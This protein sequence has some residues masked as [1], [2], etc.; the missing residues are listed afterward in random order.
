M[1]RYP[2]I[3][4]LMIV[5]TMSMAQSVDFDVC[6]ARGLQGL[7][8]QSS[9]LIGYIGRNVSVRTVGVGGPLRLEPVLIPRRITFEIDEDSLI[10]RI[11]C[12]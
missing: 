9:D 2:L 1:T 12:G 11:Y 3:V 7:I 5:P 10:R 8:G 4:A 6:G